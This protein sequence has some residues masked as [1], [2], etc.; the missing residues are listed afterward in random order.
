LHREGRDGQWSTFVFHVG[1]PPQEVR[2]LPSTGS[3]T[4][5][6]V[7][8]P[9]GC[10]LTSDPFC[11]ARGEIFSSEDSTS[12]KPAGGY[13][14]FFGQA[15]GMGIGANGAYGL[16][17]LG[18][19]FVD[20]ET[21]AL[22]SLDSQL[23]VGIVSKDYYLGFF[24]LNLQP[25]N[26]SDHNQPITSFIATLHNQGLIP[27]LTWSYTAGAHYRSSDDYGSLIFG[28]Y[29]QAKF[30]PGSGLS[31]TLDTDVTRDIVVSIPQI[32]TLINGYNE[33][34]LPPD[35]GKYNNMLM[36]IIVKQTYL[37][38]CD[39]CLHRFHNPVLVATT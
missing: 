28:G 10:N 26:L 12:W 37:C 30:L 21:G 24:G 7:A 4:T 22:L 23:I 8:E 2:L 36:V 33:T 14:L 11:E 17:T 16:D 5:Y 27:S 35:T 39:K 9:V 29:D 1:N 18:P 15:Y 19:G 38:S 25:F 34:L 20:N 32:S 6:V 3:S 13:N 31:L